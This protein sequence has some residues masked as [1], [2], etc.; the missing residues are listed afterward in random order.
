M[1]LNALFFATLKRRAGRAFFGVK[2]LFLIKIENFYQKTTTSLQEILPE[3]L[4]SVAMSANRATKPKAWKTVRCAY[5]V[6]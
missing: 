5:P 3:R 1:I 4:L 6:I 2:L